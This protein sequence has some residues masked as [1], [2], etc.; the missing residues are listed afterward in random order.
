MQILNVND[1]E[2]RKYGRV[3]TNVDFAPLVEALKKTE[4][5][6]GEP[7]RLPVA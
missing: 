3:V 7:N 5:P 1:A 2:F 6:A 4:C